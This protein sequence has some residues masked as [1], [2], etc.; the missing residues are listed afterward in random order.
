[1][2]QLA[3]KTMHSGSMQYSMVNEEMQKDGN[4]THSVHRNDQNASHSLIRADTTQHARGH[5]MS[6]EDLLRVNQVSGDGPEFFAAAMASEN[7]PIEDEHSRIM[8]TSNALVQ[9]GVNED[10]ILADSLA[11]E[12]QASATGSVTHGY[13]LAIKHSK[14]A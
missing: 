12:A 5:L 3:P 8:A 10:R 4:Q 1:M 7:A 13:N 9:G 6:N 2:L 14:S 11:L